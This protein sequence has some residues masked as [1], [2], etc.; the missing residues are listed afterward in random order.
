MTATA[1]KSIQLVGK[2]IA[3]AALGLASPGIASEFGLTKVDGL[4]LSISR[5]PPRTVF[6][7]A[8]MLSPQSVCGMANELAA[9]LK[10]VITDNVLPAVN[11]AVSK[12]A[13]GVSLVR[14]DLALSPNCMG[15]TTVAPILHEQAD[16][17]LMKAELPANRFTTNI[18]TPDASVLG[19]QVGAPQ[20]LD[21]RIT[22]TFDAD[23]EILIPL[24]RNGATRFGVPQYRVRVRNVSLPQGEN[25]SGT[26]LSWFADVG[27]SIYDHFN[28]GEIGRA[29]GGGF[30]DGGRVA[31]GIVSRLNDQ[32]VAAGQ[33]K[34]QAS[35]N[36]ASGGILVVNLHNGEKFAD[37]TCIPGFV[38]REAR[39]GD[40]VC[41]T[42]EVR[43]QVRL[44]NSRAG[45]RAVPLDP[46]VIQLQG[47]CMIGAPC[48]MKSRPPQACLSGFVWREAV[49]N[50]FVCVTPETRAQAKQDNIMALRRRVDFEEVI[51]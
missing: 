51:H 22:I 50:D 16:Y 25:A 32:I 27:T 37:P 38:W 40:L 45:E 35:I 14:Y 12:R 20:S 17:I 46:R 7:D 30:G 10:Q 24:P 49:E 1:Q 36:L 43:A 4:R 39:K 9:G 34:Q 31:G 5:D 44:D 3:L 6:E 28:N 8:Q 47:I 2:L 26:V 13:A 18:T 42:P 33:D 29:L 48:E 21:P 23:A 19:I 11:A 41:V 15:S